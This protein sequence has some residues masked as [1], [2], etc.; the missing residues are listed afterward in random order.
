MQRQDF[1]DATLH[2]PISF[3][4]SPLQKSP[5]QPDNSYG[6]Q[7]KLLALCKNQIYCYKSSTCEYT[8]GVCSVGTSGIGKTLSG[9]LCSLLYAAVT[10]LTIATTALMSERAKELA[11]EH[12]NNLFCIPQNDY[13]TP[14]QLSERAIAALFCSPDKLEFLRTLDCLGVHEAGCIPG[15]VRSIIDMILR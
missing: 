7:K 14:G 9:I 6:E 10:R 3:D 8:K 13:L 1:L 11:G 2:D 12:I 4:I 5:Q 15:E